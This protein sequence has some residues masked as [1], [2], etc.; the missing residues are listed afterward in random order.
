M[1][2]IYTC[3]LFLIYRFLWT[4]IIPVLVIRFFLISYRKFGFA[5][6]QERF[7]MYSKEK[8]FAAN[9]STFSG[10]VIWLHAVSVGETRAASPLIEKLLYAS[11]DVQIVL[12]HTTQTGLITGQKLF[13][14]YNQR[15]ISC[16]LPYD[17]G[18]A[19]RRFFSHFKPDLGLLIETEVWPMLTATSRSCGLPLFLVSGRLS[20]KSLRSMRHIGFFGRTIYQNLEGCFAQSEEDAAR[21][22]ELGLTHVPVLG[23]LKFDIVPPLFLLDRGK[24]W[25][26][27]FGNRPVWLAVSTR[28][29]EEQIILEAHRRLLLEVPDA[30][31]L[32]VPRHVNRCAQIAKE[33]AKIFK[34]IKRSSFP[35]REEIL[36]SW[37][38]PLDVSVCV[39]DT[40]GEVVAYTAAADLAFIGGSLV[41]KGGQNLIECCS[42]G[43][44]VIFGP[45]MF[46]FHKVSKDAL[47]AGAAI[48]V[49]DVS[50][51]VNAVHSLFLNKE[52][53][54]F[55]GKVALRYVERHRG[56][57]ERTFCML[58]DRL[59]ITH[60]NS[61]RSLR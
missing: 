48:Q 24:E 13:K 11:P 49:F 54:I 2:K 60:I 1:F 50:S 43:R 44:A 15:V 29:G 5:A 45:S 61:N 20:E 21:F 18:W 26:Q 59:K 47:M 55:M 38:L 53:R 40:M 57:T 56:A 4:L 3:F 27:A 28:S 37:S 17:I 52:Q 35:S 31:L 36:S 46:N 34:T 14:K 39:G 19:I 10:R 6:I 12:T 7:G 23:N 9:R 22:R 16:Y 41:P 51:L 42:V 8:Q 33:S 30:L 32:L 58:F 25:R